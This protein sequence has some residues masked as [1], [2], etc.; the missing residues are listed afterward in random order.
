MNKKKRKVF[1]VDSSNDAPPKTLQDD[2]KSTLLLENMEM[3]TRSVSNTPQEVIALQ[4]LVPSFDNAN[5]ANDEQL[6]CKL[7]TLEKKVERLIALLENEELIKPLK[8]IVHNLDSIK[9]QNKI[10]VEILYK[11]SK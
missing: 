5:N 1:V 7:N 10:V 3:L 11:I 4:S 2:D 8:D 9:E 6:S